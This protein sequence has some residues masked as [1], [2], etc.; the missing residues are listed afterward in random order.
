MA[1]NAKIKFN[2]PFFGN[3]HI[4]DFL[5]ESIINR[6]LSHF[7]IFSGPADLGKGTLARQ[8]AASILCQNFS[9]GQGLLPCGECP[10]CRQ[11]NRNVHGDLLELKLLPDKN[12]IGVEQVRDFIRLMNLGSFTSFRKVGII[13][14]GDSL[15]L[16][17][18]NALLKTLE[19]PKAGVTIIML[20]SSPENLPLTISSRGQILNFYPASGSQ[21]YDYL[22]QEHR[23]SRDSALHISRVVCGRP[24]LAAKMFQEKG[25][26][27]QRLKIGASL[28]SMLSLP[29]GQRFAIIENLLDDLKD[30]FSDA[31]EAAAEILTVWQ[32]TARDFM[33]GALNLEDMMADASVAAELQKMKLPAASLLM[34]QQNISDSRRYLEANVNPKAA[35]ENVCYL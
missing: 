18:A 20:S 14:P 30:S 32:A 3:R 6:S 1:N 34:L 4:I 26:L 21:I 17:A 29:L 9:V 24:A 13:K 25:F 28:T 19:E 12:N 35:L 10:S 31:R 16:E 23:A 8:L 33:L 22:I 2:W 15:S 5:Q 11:A 7:Y 27:N